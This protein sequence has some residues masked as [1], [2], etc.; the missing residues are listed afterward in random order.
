MSATIYPLPTWT[1]YCQ[2]DVISAL[3]TMLERAK[4]GEFTSVAIAATTTDLRGAYSYSDQVNGLAL[5]GVIGL[6][7]DDLADAVRRDSQ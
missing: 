3:E 7:R 1:N 2:A 4:A 5:L 6:M